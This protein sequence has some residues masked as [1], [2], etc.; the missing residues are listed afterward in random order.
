MFTLYA[1][2]EGHELTWERTPALAKGSVE[3]DQ[4]H[5]TF[6]ESWNGYTKVALFWATDA[7]D[8]LG[9]SV[10][11]AGYA[12]IPHEVLADKGR[13]KIGV[14]GKPVGSNTP[15]MTST[16]LGYS[17]EQGAWSESIG[18]SGSPTASMIEQFE[19]AANQAIEDAQE[20][21]E[22]VRRKGTLYFQEL[23]HGK[24][25][26]NAYSEQNADHTYLNSNGAEVDGSTYS[27]LSHYIPIEAG[28]V[29]YVTTGTTE[30]SPR[31]VVFYDDDLNIVPVPNPD[32]PSVTVNAIDAQTHPA[33]EAP[34]SSVAMRFVYYI[35]RKYTTVQVEEVESTSSPAT[36]HE[37]FIPDIN[38]YNMIMENT[39]AHANANYEV[40]GEPNLFNQYSRDNINGYY[41]NH[42]VI[43]ANSDY[44]ISHYI[45]VSVGSFYLFDCGKYVNSSRQTI[46]NYCRWA[47]YDE[48][49]EIVLADTAPGVQAPEGAVCLRISYP[50]EYIDEV[51]VEEY[52]WMG[53][54]SHNENLF[55]AY[56]QLNEDGAYIRYDDATSGHNLYISTDDWGMS[57]YIPVETGGTYKFCYTGT[58]TYPRVLLYKEDFTFSSTAGHELYPDGERHVGDWWTLNIPQGIYWIR[59][60]YVLARRYSMAEVFNGSGTPDRYRPYVGNTVGYGDHFMAY[61]PDTIYCAVG[62]TIDIYNSQVCLNPEWY[63]VRWVCDVG[64]SY[65]R[66]FS[67]TGTVENIGDYSLTLYVHDKEG[68]MLYCKTAKLSIV[69][70]LASNKAMLMIGDSLTRPNKPVIPEIMLLSGNR[71]TSVGTYN[72]SGSE[73]AA[74]SEG[75]TVSVVSE[76]RSG[77][78]PYEYL[79][80][81]T[82]SNPFYKSNVGFDWDFYWDAV[83]HPETYPDFVCIF[84][85][86][87]GMHQTPRRQAAYVK[88]I[89]DRIKAADANVKILVCHTIYRSNQN[90]IAIETGSDGYSNDRTIGAFKRIEDEK[91]MGYMMELDKALYGTSNVYMVPVA[92]SMDAEYNFG[93]RAVPVNPRNSNFV[94]MMPKESIH[95]QACGYYQ[96]AD[97]IYSAICAVV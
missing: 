8:P 90:G 62:R 95:P 74:D 38:E 79:N 88:A 36:I 28:K 69:S 1:K 34:T 37:P 50:L 66:K 21:L 27:G 35:S 63:H 75:N 7:S 77:M 16:L 61:L 84:L 23:A 96:M 24:N 64:Y 56:S 51:I 2:L 60:P 33:I 3:V 67:I 40:R 42:G 65:E 5:F 47:L 4:I 70:G 41:L 55:N 91:V 76:S 26:F 30:P 45:P 13:I 43:T 72:K 57:H 78:S 10:S 81:S 44:G 18:N 59:V 89:V 25:L 15:R 85:G 17:V 20:L 39:S 29:Y 97:V 32:N 6:D 48:Y 68:R 94:E 82:Q 83:G 73:S 86:T 9:V 58:S 46:H 87:N 53:T 11:G 31:Y 52:S 14:Y 71:I 22:D 12:T 92:V 80:T 19:A 54:N 49:G 93:M